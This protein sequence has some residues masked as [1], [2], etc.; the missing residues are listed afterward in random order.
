MVSKR[1][2]GDDD[3]EG[4]KKAMEAMKRSQLLNY[5]EAVQELL[6]SRAEQA[7]SRLDNRRIVP[8]EDVSLPAKYRR[9]RQNRWAV[10]EKEENNNGDEAATSNGGA[11]VDNSNKKP[12]DEIDSMSAMFENSNNNN[13]ATIVSKSMMNTEKGKAI[14]RRNIEELSFINSLNLQEIAKGIRYSLFNNKANR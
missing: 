3:E 6:N 2:L 13:D 11:A 5:Q 8:L 9:R 14:R 4:K 10:E 7:T 1:N 12:T